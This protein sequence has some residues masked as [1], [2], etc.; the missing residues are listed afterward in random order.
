MNGRKAV[1]LK[2]IIAELRRMA[3]ISYEVSTV[4]SNGSSCRLNG[5]SGDH[6]NTRLQIPNAHLIVNKCIIISPLPHR[7]IIDCLLYFNVW[8]QYHISS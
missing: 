4:P 1:G 6:I 7:I 2:D 5:I 8:Q 3:M